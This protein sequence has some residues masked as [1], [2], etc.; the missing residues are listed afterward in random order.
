MKKMYSITELCQLTSVSVRTLHYYDEINLLT[1][2]FRA[3]NRHRR[4]D[5]NDLARLQQIV[6]L[7]YLGFSL[8]QIHKIFKDNKFDI[9][10]SL[11]MQGEALAE[12]RARIKKACNLLDYLIHQR[13]S[14]KVID[15]SVGSK[16]IGIL[17]LNENDKANWYKKY[18]DNA[19]STTYEKFAKTRTR[20]WLALFEEI[21]KNLKSSPDSDVAKNLLKKWHKL[22]D[23]A[24]GKTP[25]LKTKLWEAYKA[26]LIP[27]MPYDK[28]VITYLSKAGEKISP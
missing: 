2:S 19:E 21:K 13:E 4:Y 6:T 5:E 14:N 20:E 12:E 8:K 17:N 10:A 7:K 23:A 11:K 25:A 1:P 26:G 22:A 15:W 18:L 3:N 28:K 24:Y 16:I 9:Y 27:D